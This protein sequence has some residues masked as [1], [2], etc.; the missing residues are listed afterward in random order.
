LG[1]DVKTGGIEMSWT[2]YSQIKTGIRSGEIF[3]IKS[4]DFPTF[5]D[6]RHHRITERFVK[7]LCKSGTEYLKELR[8]LGFHNQFISDDILLFN[9]GKSI[10]YQYNQRFNSHGRSFNKFIK[11]KK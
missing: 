11:D 5:R 1:K 4:I 3:N 2:Y 6:T 7:A 8:L 10:A 9:R